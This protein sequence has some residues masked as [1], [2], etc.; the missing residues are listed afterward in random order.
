MPTLFNFN[1]FH[2]F[3]Y[4]GHPAWQKD[5]RSSAKLICLYYITLKTN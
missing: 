4:Y 5:V 1:F 2:D 3:N